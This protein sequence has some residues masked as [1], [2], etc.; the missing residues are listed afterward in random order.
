MPR[1][2]YRPETDGFAFKN[3]WQ[4]DSTE[5]GVLEG[6]V[7]DA[8]GVIEVILSPFIWAAEGPVLA[9]ELGVP[10]IGP[11]LV[12]KTIEAENN[13]IVNAIV[14]AITA[15]SYGL[16]GGMAFASLDYWLK[17]WVMPRGTGPADQPQRTSPTGTALRN[18]IWT[19]LLQSVKDN[20]GTFLQ[21]MAV[22][23]FEGGPGAT[24]LRD[25]TLVELGKL[26]ARINAGTPVTIGLIGTTWNPLDNHQV[27]VYGYDDNPDGTTTLFIYDNNAPGV[28][29][30]T[31]LDF[32]GATLA[33]TESI[34]YASGD[35]G[36]L[37]GLFCTTYGAATPP[38]TVVLRQ[39]LTVA[40]AVTGT[41]D[42]VGV[43][44]TVANIGYHASPALQLVI[45]GDAG[46][47]VQEP[48]DTSIAEGGARSLAGNLTFAAAGNH[49][50]AAV[51]SLGT[52]QGVA[53]TKFLPPEGTTQSPSG[54]A[55]IVVD[56]LIDFDADYTCEVGNVAGAELTYSVRIDDMGPG[57]TYQ[58]T[59]TGA[60]LVL[61]ATSQQVSVKLP[62]QA[63]ASV[64][65]GVRVTRPDGGFST[66]SYTFATI[67]SQAAG[68]EQLMCEIAH[69]ITVPPFQTNPGDPGPAIPRVV[70]PGDIAALASAAEKLATA[71]NAASL[72]GAPLVLSPA[73][74]L[75]LAVLPVATPVA[76]VPV[77]IV[78]TLA[79][80]PVVRAVEPV[81]AK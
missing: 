10:F 72:T 59:V 46:A 79:S 49:K 1:T 28:E 73:P 42:P 36:P 35:R 47:P 18:Y 78:P 15:K 52:F 51:A 21:W 66:G 80:T 13:A 22:L 3:T 2:Q 62:A 48:A 29:L 32:S 31:R 70:N 74:R 65:L 8:V 53:I 9:A 7:T 57:L 4:F 25:Q 67:T 44:L 37:R 19:R 33:A 27:L 69:I 40:P 55:D 50:I 5:T 11:W 60:S 39:G 12:A 17:S 63:G 26:K 77:A 56:R 38:S 58:W 75:V 16:C 61:G 54:S 45:A 30:T 76:A 81:T 68:L 64:T 14:G 43:G 23:H 71:A 41:G 24:W 34:D 6:L 20:V